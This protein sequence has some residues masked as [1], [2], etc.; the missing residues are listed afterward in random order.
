MSCLAQLMCPGMCT[1]L[2]VRV[3]SGIGSH[4]EKD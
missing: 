4:G 1:I 2:M 3:S